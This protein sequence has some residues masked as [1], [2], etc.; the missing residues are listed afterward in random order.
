MRGLG[1]ASPPQ[2][3]TTYSAFSNHSAAS[4]KAFSAVMP[5]AQALRQIESRKAAESRA[6]AAGDESISI[7]A[8]NEDQFS[9][10]AEDLLKLLKG[11]PPPKF[12]EKRSF[13][14][15]MDATVPGDLVHIKSEVRFLSPPLPASSEI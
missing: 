12:G 6:A 8:A 1:F 4:M 3:V 14:S 9:D 5:S 15:I 7:P 13:L 2:L 10:P 11:R